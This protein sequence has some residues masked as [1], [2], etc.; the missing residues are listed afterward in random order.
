MLARNVRL[1]S[2]Y[3]SQVERMSGTLLEYTKN[4]LILG[5]LSLPLMLIAFTMIM[6]FGLGNVG[7]ILLFL[8]QITVVPAATFLSNGIFGFI[9]SKLG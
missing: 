6:G 5:F 7:M 3:C 8:G 9:K 1:P 2:K 4:I